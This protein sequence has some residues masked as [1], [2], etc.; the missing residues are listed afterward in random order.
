MSEI[1]RKKS[2]GSKRK[3]PTLSA[4]EESAQNENENETPKTAEIKKKKTKKVNDTEEESNVITHNDNE[5]EPKMAAAIKKKK[6]K[7]VDDD[8]ELEATQV[9]ASEP[10]KKSMGSTI[11]SDQKFSELP[12]GDK[13]KNA[14]VKMGFEYMT[15]IQAKSIPECLGGIY[16]D[17]YM[18]LY[19]NMCI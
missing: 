15:E 11:L 14:L 6:T 16:K 1:N 8:I 4:P 2:S 18:H 13:T 7:K 19:I 10:V 9:I 5:E 3:A 12:I 17:I